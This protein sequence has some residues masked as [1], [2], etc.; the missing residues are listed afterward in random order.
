MSFLAF[1]TPIWWGQWRYSEVTLL[2]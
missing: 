2:N 1:N